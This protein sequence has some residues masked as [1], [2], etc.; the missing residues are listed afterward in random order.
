VRRWLHWQFVLPRVLLVVVALLATQYVLGIV[1]RSMAV[2]SAE[3]ALGARVEIGHARVSL[4][5]RQLVFND[6]RITNGHHHFGGILQADRCVLNID[7][8]PLAHKRLV[9]ES[10]QVGGLRF[11]AAEDGAVDS[12]DRESAAARPNAWFK[13]DA[14]LA[15]RQWLDSLNEQF[16]CDLVKQLDS[17]ERTDAFC[18]KWS[19]QSAAL[20]SRLQEWDA[21]ATKLQEAIETA[22]AN[23]LRNEKL[24][25]DLRTKVAALQQEFAVFRADVDK[26]PDELDNERRA[27]VAARRHDGQLVGERLHLEPVQAKAL[28]SYL[29]REQ[30]AQR[31]N[32]IVG[33]MR[34][35]REVIPAKATPPSGTK[36]GENIVFADCQQKPGI[37]IRSLQLAGA[38]Q[39]G[40]QPVELRGM[41]TSLA[42]EPMLHDQPLRLHLVGRGSMPL[43]L[44]AT[45][46]RRGSIPRDEL[47]VDCQGMLVPAATLGSSDQFEMKLA[48][49]VGALSVSISVEG[50]KLTGDIQMVQQKVQ[51][52]PE[53]HGPAGPALCSAMGETLG[54]NSIATRLSLG[55]TLSKPTCTL[56]SNLGTAVAESLRHALRRAGDQ[57][58]RE[59]LAEAGRRVDE[60]LAEVDRQMAE[61]QQHFTSQATELNARLDE[62]AAVEKPLYRISA[63][64]GG[65]RLPKD[66]LFR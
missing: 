31:L 40:G 34:W 2:R 50:E 1:V 52:T 65:R 41:L 56:W 7:V 63:K 15:A 27:I 44:Q 51:I 59:L 26:L 35:M 25:K 32:E 10:G 12:T 24:L 60:R 57:H 66:S 42:S 47:L 8:A 53:V 5:D 18:A 54:V 19:Q 29:L 62:L 30:T 4:A 39:I 55:G 37:L 58:E 20:K 11:G 23:P 16:G 14:D 48:P 13:D 3:R 28:N 6:V 61:Q 43:E 38:A 36:R 45:I 49:S 64:Q 46:D 9:V 22:Q 17:V 21:R 33:W